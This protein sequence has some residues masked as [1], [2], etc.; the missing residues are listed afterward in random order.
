MRDTTK[1]NAYAAEFR[2]RRWLDVAD[3]C[4]TVFGS[5]WCPEAE[6]KFGSVESVQHYANRVLQ[7]IDEPRPI[8]VR[9]RRGQTKAHYEGWTSTIALP[10]HRI[11]GTWALRE[12]VVLHEIAHHLSISDPGHGED[13]ARQFVRLHDDLGYPVRATLLRIALNE[14]G[15][16]I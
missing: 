13:F 14:E 2:F 12:T 1:G 3:P 8:T 6:V 15:L 7:H 16:T 5:T 9:E 11:G 4:V 10:P